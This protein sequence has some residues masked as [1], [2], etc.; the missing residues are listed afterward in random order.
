MWK[1]QNKKVAAPQKD[2]FNTGNKEPFA[3]AFGNHG[4]ELPEVTI[5]D[6]E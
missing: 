5:D 2:R 4:R 6:Y 1:R 3:A